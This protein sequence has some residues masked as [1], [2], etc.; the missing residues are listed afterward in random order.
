MTRLLVLGLLLYTVYSAD[1][2]PKLTDEQRAE[3][4]KALLDIDWKVLPDRD[5]I[6]KEFVFLNFN[7]A[8][9]FMTQVAL[10]AEKVNHHPEWFNIHKTVEIT[11][12]TN[13]SG[14][15]TMKD[16]EMGKFI[17]KS[18]KGFKPCPKPKVAEGQS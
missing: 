3:D 13:E 16:I 8:F 14:G 15:L 9:S 10:H 11:L 18:A 4:L 1:D 17:E 6:Y 7:E 5:A 2:I 12:S